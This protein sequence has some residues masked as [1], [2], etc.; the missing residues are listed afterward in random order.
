MPAQEDAALGCRR[1]AHHI[2]V[3]S[4]K[5]KILASTE[6]P[7]CGHVCEGA[8]WGGLDSQSSRVTQALSESPLYVC[9]PADLGNSWGQGWLQPPQLWVYCEGSFMSRRRKLLW[10]TRQHLWS[11]DLSC[12]PSVHILVGCSA[13]PR[14]LGGMHLSSVFKAQVFSLWKPPHGG[15]WT[16]QSFTWP[17]RS[18]PGG[19]HTAPCCGAT[20]HTCLLQ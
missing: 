7:V 13:H 11:P 4:G 2:S 9:V 18:S 10:L 6:C 15:A 8:P 14:Q 19:D 1:I 5:I 12:T 16:W 20:A 3:C 17:Y